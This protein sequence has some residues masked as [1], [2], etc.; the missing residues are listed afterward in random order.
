MITTEDLQYL[1]RATPAQLMKLKN[2]IPWEVCCWIKA[3]LTHPRQFDQEVS[4]E[5]DKWKAAGAVADRA[6]FERWLKA[7]GG[8]CRECGLNPKSER[9]VAF[10]QEHGFIWINLCSQCCLDFDHHHDVMKLMA[11][12]AALSRR[13]KGRCLTRVEGVA[14]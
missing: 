13:W 2:G 6:Y 11:T 4:R 5:M 12:S 1:K 3:E 14:R 10:T 9:R 7:G 8:A